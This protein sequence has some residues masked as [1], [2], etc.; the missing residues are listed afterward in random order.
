MAAASRYDLLVRLRTLREERKRLEQRALW[1]G[2]TQ[3]LRG[4]LIERHLGSGEARRARG[5]WSLSL[6]GED[7]TTRLRYVRREDLERLRRHVEAYRE[8]R[9]AIRRLRVLGAQILEV[10]QSLA[11]QQ[12]ATPP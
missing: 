3:L 12:E 2:Q 10:L 7:G 8:C 6:R 1:P 4:S 5:A 11:R 9:A